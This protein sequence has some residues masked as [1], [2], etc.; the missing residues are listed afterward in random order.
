MSEMHPN[1]GFGAVGCLGH[2]RPMPISTGWVGADRVHRL[3]EAVEPAQPR[4][5]SD[6][7]RTTAG[8]CP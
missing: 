7:Y 5:D 6:K 3:A 1:A 4:P 2:R 8:K